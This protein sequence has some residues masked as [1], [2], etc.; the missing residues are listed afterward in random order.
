[1]IGSIATVSPE[2]VKERS[3]ENDLIIGGYDMADMKTMTTGKTHMISILLII[4]ILAGC[5]RG[6]GSKPVKLEGYWKGTITLASGTLGIMVQFR[7]KG[8]LSAHIDIPAQGAWQV[9]LEKVKF[10]Y[11]DISFELPSQPN[12]A[13]FSGKYADNVISGTVVQG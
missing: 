2:P 13:R 7:V 1:M 9:R 12:Y 6:G 5:G 11:P 4:C 10:I 8:E 3:L